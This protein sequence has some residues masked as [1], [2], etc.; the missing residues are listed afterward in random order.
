M[1]V[2]SSPEGPSSLRD[3]CLVPPV[4]VGLVVIPSKLGL[5]TEGYSEAVPPWKAGS[6]SGFEN[7]LVV[8]KL[9]VTEWAESLDHLLG[10]FKEEGNKAVFPGIGP[11][12]A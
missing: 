1:H 7:H 2:V 6:G 12:P 9:Q 3:L 10:L 5:L 11:C 8:G 4:T